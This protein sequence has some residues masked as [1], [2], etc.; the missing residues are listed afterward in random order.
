M[1]DSFIAAVP[2]LVDVYKPD[3]LILTGFLLLKLTKIDEWL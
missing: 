1:H 3:R 2:V